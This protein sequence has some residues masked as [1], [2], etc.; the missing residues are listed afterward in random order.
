[1][2]WRVRRSDLL[3]PDS[4]RVQ[5]VAGIEVGAGEFTELLGGVV[6][7]AVSETEINCT[8]KADGNIEELRNHGFVAVERL[9]AALL[10]G[11][12]EHTMWKGSL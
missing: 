10:W 2:G 11:K 1:M 6:E 5:V 12:V 7:L 8:P 3:V 4:T 9:F